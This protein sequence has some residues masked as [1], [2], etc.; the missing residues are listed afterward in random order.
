MITTS[1]SELK[2]RLPEFADR[3]EKERERFM[4]LREGRPS[5]VLLSAEDW[6]DVQETIFWLAQP[7]NGERL[8]TAAAEV[9]E[10]KVYGVTEIQEALHRFRG[11]P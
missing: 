5:V 11:K 3:A 4:A 7:G 2:D 9:D 8:A 6:E 1:L 10:G